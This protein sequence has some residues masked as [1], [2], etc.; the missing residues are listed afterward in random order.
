MA[1]MSFRPMPVP[2]DEAER[3]AALRRHKLLATALLGV[4]AV[5]FLSMQYLEIKSGLDAAWVGYVRAAAEAGMVGGL[6]DW[7]AVTALFKYPMGL[8]IPH[9]AIVKNK[10]DQVG[11]AMSE[12]VGEN[13]LNAELITDKVR[14]YGIPDRLAVWL[15]EP[16]NAQKVSAESGKLIANV[17]RALDPADAE[18]LIR[19]ALIEKAAEPTWGPPIGRVLEQLIADGKTEPMVEEVVQWMHRKAV[20]SED[21]VV[22]VIDERMPTWAPRFVHDLVGERV[23]REVV[24]WTATVAAQP[25]HEARQAIRKFINNLAQDLQFD[26][27]M[28]SRVEEWK[29]EIMGSRQVEAAPAL[30][31]ESA[32]K[33][34]I[35]AAEDADSLLRAKIAE[36]SLVWGNN[37]R[38]DSALRDSLDRRIT[39]ATRFLADNLAPAV[40]EII[41]ET[42]E[43]WDAEEASDKIE[44][45][46]G[47]DLQYI[48]LNGT[49]VG[50]LAGLAIY[51]LSQLI[52]AA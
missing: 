31:W 40:S 5:I 35:A 16:D 2:S 38:D 3:R 24:Q 19:K 32:A 27:V 39:G 20:T 14:Q 28:I 23:H 52:F 18:H 46:V 42:V 47:K 13:F 9:T 41:S 11:V 6:A 8:K 50:A 37:L 1:G 4:A 45:M 34:I 49:I 15:S 44:L 22:K 36:L 33:S 10:K 43:R 26:S 21:F 48:R 29:A 30:L 12:F 25:N 17:V 7:F 51:T